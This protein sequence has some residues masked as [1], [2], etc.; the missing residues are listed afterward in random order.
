MRH[1]CTYLD[2]WVRYFR[3]SVDC[4]AFGQSTAPQQ[5]GVFVLGSYLLAGHI[6]AA[7]VNIPHQQSRRLANQ[8]PDPYFR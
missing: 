3:A 8:S 5:I 1:I 2:M 7:L 6:S 4:A